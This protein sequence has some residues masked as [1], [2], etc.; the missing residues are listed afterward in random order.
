M[1]EELIGFLVLIFLT[2]LVVAAV[3]V[4]VFVVLLRLLKYVKKNGS[5]LN[6]MEKKLETLI[7]KM[8]MR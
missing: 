7:Y 4:G 6:S 3:M 1:N 8:R 5:D 2:L